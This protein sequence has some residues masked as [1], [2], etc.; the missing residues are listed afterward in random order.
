MNLKSIAAMAL[1]VVATSGVAHA[2]SDSKCGAGSCSKKVQS[3]KADASCS[4]KQ[5]AAAKAAK[6]DASCSKKEAAGA[7]KEAGCSKKEASCSK[8]AQSNH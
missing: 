5:A 2:G 1:T 7:K 3:T 8:K 4:K 6:K